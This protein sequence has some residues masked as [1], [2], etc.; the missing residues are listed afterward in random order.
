MGSVAE[1]VVSRAHGFVA[2]LIFAL[3]GRADEA[4]VAPTVGFVP[5]TPDKPYVHVIHQGRTV[6]IQRAQNP[7]YRL[8]GYFAKSVRKCPPFCLQSSTPDPRVAAVGEV[9]LF[10][11]IENS[12]R[13]GTGMLVDARSPRWFAN[14][15]IPGS[16]NYPPRLFLDETD[17]SRMDGVLESFGA[18]RRDSIGWWTRFTED[19][20]LVDASL[21]TAQ[22]DFSAAKDLVVFCHG[23]TCE[24]APR[25]IR[26]L[27]AAGYPG[28]K[29]RYYRGGLQM[30]KFWGLT[31]VAPQQ[32]T[33]SAATP[34]RTETETR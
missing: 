32:Q 22:W 16:V 7:E 1:R 6:K 19:W 24:K 21:K 34:M 12:L 31:T 8:E 2:L 33:K 14:E 20:G 30:W 28:E 3:P 9:E 13:D 25:A 5:L 29:L 17:T 4:S 23:P 11:F 18:R 26:A 27:L 10:D 15:T